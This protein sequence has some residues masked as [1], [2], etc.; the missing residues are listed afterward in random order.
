M[1]AISTTTS[2]KLKEILEPMTSTQPVTLRYPSNTSRSS[3][4]PGNKHITE[5]EVEAD[6]EMQGQFLARIILCRDNHAEKI[7]KIYGN[8]NN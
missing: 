2:S 1:A 5:A 8:L 4:Y 7:S 6:I 3:Y